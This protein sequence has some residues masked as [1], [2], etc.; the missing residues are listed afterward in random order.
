MTSLVYSIFHEYDNIKS[1]WKGG[2]DTTVKCK[3]IAPDYPRL[4][5]CQIHALKSHSTLQELYTDYAF[6]SYL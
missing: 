3:T 6:I 1:H 5:K 4:C 2:L